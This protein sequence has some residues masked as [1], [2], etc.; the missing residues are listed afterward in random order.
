L[1]CH[2]PCRTRGHALPRAAVI[3]A[4]GAGS[5]L[6]LA[7]AASAHVT[8]NPSSATAGSFAQLDFR[9]PTE[10][11]SASTVGVEVA[12]PTDHPIAN[13]SVQPKAGWTYTVTRTK[14]A[15]P[16]KTDDGNVTEAISRISWKATAGGLKPGEFDNFTVSAGP[17]P[18]DVASITLPAIQTYSDGS[19]V[20]WIEPRVTSGPE[21]DHPAPVLT[22][23]KA[24]TTDG[25]TDTSTDTSTTAS[26][27]PASSSSST[28]ST[29]RTLG[30]IGIVLGVLGLGV[31]GV[32]VLRR[33]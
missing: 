30:I 21:P 8:V 5:V 17:L 14:L 20:R 13:I 2:L 22:L 31:G 18:T 10:S 9:V 25:A 28:D 7:A 26:S 33:R 3:V 1:R 23:T 29:A 19:V 4:V 16:I 6:G 24:S 32:A 11:D 12:F 15:T 27:A